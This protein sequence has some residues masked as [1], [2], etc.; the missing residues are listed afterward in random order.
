MVVKHL[1]PTNMTWVS[2][3]EAMQFFFHG[4]SLLLVL[5]PPL[6]VFLPRYSGFQLSIKR[7]Q[8]QN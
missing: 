7:K 8:Q 3:I 1:S 6:R 4:L 2:I 5:A